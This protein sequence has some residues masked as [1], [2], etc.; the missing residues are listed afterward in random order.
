MQ[1]RL[2]FLGLDAVWSFGL[3]TN[4]SKGFLPKVRLKPPERREREIQLRRESSARSFVRWREEDVVSH[5][6]QPFSGIWG[7]SF[8]PESCWWQNSAIFALLNS[9]HLP[10]SLSLCLLEKDGFLMLGEDFA[11]RKVRLLF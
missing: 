5:S 6:L 11:K 10:H 8:A 2:S 1:D 3:V 7:L 4:E 9:S